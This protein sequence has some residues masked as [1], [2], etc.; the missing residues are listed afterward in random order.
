MRHLLSTLCD[1]I[2]G[3]HISKSDSFN[4]V[5]MNSN[6]HNAGNC[7]VGHRRYVGDLDHVGG[8]CV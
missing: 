1:W 5:I 6:I 7:D 3:S 2:S 8:F 4:T